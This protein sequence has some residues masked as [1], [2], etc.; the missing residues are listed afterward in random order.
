MLKFLGFMGSRLN[1]NNNLLK[2]RRLGCWFEILKF[3]LTY[4][5][6]DHVYSINQ[7][8][9]LGLSETIFYSQIH[10]RSLLETLSTGLLKLDWTGGTRTNKFCWPLGIKRFPSFARQHFLPIFLPVP[11]FEIFPPMFSSLTDEFTESS[12]DHIAN[13]SDDLSFSYLQGM[14]QPTE[15]I[16]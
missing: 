7:I 16:L 2:V 5:M 9:F 12:N 10:N 15:K 1:L 3:P 11:F 4:C 6:R 14:E 8:S 13:S